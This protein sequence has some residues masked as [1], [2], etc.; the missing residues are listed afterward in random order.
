MAEFTKRIEIIFDLINKRRYKSSET[1]GRI[2]CETVRDVP[3]E[4]E[5][6]RERASIFKVIN[7]LLGLQLKHILLL[8]RAASKKTKPQCSTF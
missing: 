1:S 4:R 8:E 3:R 2:D 5:R 6:E 7:T